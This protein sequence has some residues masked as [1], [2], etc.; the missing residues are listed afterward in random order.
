[1]KFLALLGREILRQIMVGPA[2]GK[3]PPLA[4]ATSRADRASAELAP[5]GLKFQA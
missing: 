2:A 5:K 4:I 3:R 1:M